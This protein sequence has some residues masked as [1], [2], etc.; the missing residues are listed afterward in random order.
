MSVEIAFVMCMANF[1]KRTVLICFATTFL[2]TITTHSSTSLGFK[3]VSSFSCRIRRP[4]KIKRK[5]KVILFTPFQNG[6]NGRN[7]IHGSAAKEFS[8]RLSVLGGPPMEDYENSDRF[9]GKDDNCLRKA[10]KFET[11]LAIVPPLED[12]DR[13]QRARHYA[14]DPVFREWPP[15]I[16]LFHPFDGSPNIAFD[17]SQLV[18]DLELEAFQITLDTWVIVPNVE[19]TQIEWKNQQVLPD[20]VEGGT[21]DSYYEKLNQQSDKE[22]QELIKEEERKAKIKALKKNANGMTGQQ[23]EDEENETLSST[24]IRGK[25]SPAE[26]RDEQRKSIE[27]DFGGPCLLCL[28]PDEESKEKLIEL[29]E[30]I[31]E[32]LGL[33]SYSSPSSLYT[34]ELVEHIDMGYRPLIPI[35][36]FDSF[37]TAMGIAR[38]LKGLWGE[39]LTIDVKSLEI[40]SCQTS[41]DTDANIKD[42]WETIQYSNHNRFTQQA[43][44]VGV[45]EELWGCNAKIMLVGEE[46]EQDVVVNEEMVDRLLEQGEI[47]GGDISMDFTILD[48]EEESVTNIEKWLDEDDDFD[49]GTQV[50]IGRTHFFTGDQRNYKGMPATS[51]VDAKDRSLGEVG[52]V[53]GLAAEEGLQVGRRM[54]G[55]KVN[56]ED[57]TKTSSLGV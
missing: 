7:P 51:V 13:L 29:R 20:V 39:P 1:S 55:T 48:D 38:R 42:E 41:D 28:E 31:R 56:M 16:R 15:A 54:F 46:S 36:K 47:G 19:A 44:Q 52:S 10:S 40:L 24:V 5:G 22:V 57:E 26:I 50:I 3:K 27:D 18:E 49:E 33:Q 9:V 2:S 6:L 4:E 8:S 34:W 32:G 12:W 25:K 17:I 53:S 11:A 43:S 14:R 23:N 21:L 35:S 37:Q 30:L 45:K